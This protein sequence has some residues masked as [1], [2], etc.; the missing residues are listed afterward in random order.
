MNGQGAEAFFT[1]AK[2]A[3]S[4]YDSADDFNWYL[5]KDGIAVVFGEYE[6]ASYAA[7]PQILVIPYSEFE[8]K[9]DI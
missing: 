1:T 8:M 6:I 4:Y 5:T 3:V 7:G 2:D 9:I